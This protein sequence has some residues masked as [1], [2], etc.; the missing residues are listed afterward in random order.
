MSYKENKGKGYALK[1]GVQQSKSDYLLYTDHDFPY[2]YGSMVELIEL[3]TS[4]EDRK[5]V[6][7]HRGKQYYKNKPLL[8]IKV[9]HYLKTLNRF[10]LQLNTDDTQ[11]GLKAFRKSIKPVFLEAKTNRFLID[12][13]FLRRL[14]R[15]KIIVHVVDVKVRDNIIMSNVGF[16]T[17]LHELFSYIRILLTT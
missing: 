8:R 6:I 17:I 1:H 3:L 4:D 13:E 15:K 7:G 2:T 10:I 14:R 12:I 5:V 11:C 16:K 9:S